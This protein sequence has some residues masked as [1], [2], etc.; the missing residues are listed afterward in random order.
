MKIMNRRNNSSMKWDYK[1]I[2]KR[3]LIDVDDA[4]TFYPLFIADM[5]FKM[6]K[7]IKEKL[8]Q[9]VEEP[10][11]GYYFTKE[12]FFESIIDWYKDIHS[13]DIHKDWIVPSVGTIASMH[14]ACDMLV[15]NED[16]LIF[17]PVYGPFFNCAKIGN[18][19]SLPLLL[20]NGQYSIDYVN[21]EKLFKEQNIK[22]LLFCNPHNPGGKTWDKDELYKLVLL[23]KQYNVTI[24]SDE[25]HGDFIL[26]EKKYTSLIEYSD[27]Y[28]QIIVSTSPNKTFNISG[29]STSFVL[30]ANKELKARYESYLAKLHLGCNRLGM[31]MI[32]YVYTYGKDWYLD[33]L[34]VI[35]NNVNKIVEQAKEAGCEVMIPE[36]GFLVWVHLPGIKDVSQFIL[37]LAKDT[38]VL[39]ETGARFVDNYDGWVRI[40]AATSSE[41]VNTA[42]TLFKNYY[43]NY[44]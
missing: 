14:L 22:V 31:D 21:L 26:T 19:K 29:L 18:P 10:D 41:L 42:M 6:D 33:V 28:D 37:D 43:K 3:F 34:K 9:L 38:H 2:K 44:K 17:T 24:L 25:I 15:N 5:D 1:Y 20:H 30:C 16:V 7:N 4:S 23:C 36:G 39:L 8:H 35:K 13:I 40:N 32:E 27:I 12:S 11:F